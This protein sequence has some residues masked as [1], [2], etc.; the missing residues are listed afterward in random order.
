[1]EHLAHHLLPAAVGREAHQDPKGHRAALLKA[2]KLLVEPSAHNL[3]PA[4]VGREA[5]RDPKGHN[6]AALL[7][8]AELLVEPQAHLLPPAAVG[9]EAHRDPRGHKLS[10]AP[11]PGAATR[12]PGTS[13]S[14]RTQA[15]TATTGTRSTGARRRTLH[16]PASGSGGGSPARPPTRPPA[17]APRGASAP[18]RGRWTRGT[19]PARGLSGAGCGPRRPRPGLA[20]LS[21]TRGRASRALPGST[22]ELAFYTLRKH[23]HH[24]HNH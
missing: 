4:A 11:L 6:K 19:L 24:Q 1:M 3:L 13:T 14:T 8:A 22:T 10:T 16:R 20:G 7:E 21:R 2:A 17:A 5:H 18:R 23:H 9:R 12:G 15:T